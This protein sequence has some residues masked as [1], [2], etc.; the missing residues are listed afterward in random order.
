MAEAA[1]TA[2]AAS[3]DSGHAAVCHANGPG[4][5]VRGR[6]SIPDP[7]SRTGQE[8]ASRGGPQLGSNQRHLLWKFVYLPRPTIDCRSV[9]TRPLPLTRSEMLL[10]SISFSRT[11]CP[12]PIKGVA[13][14]PAAGRPMETICPVAT[15]WTM[16]TLTF[17]IYFTPFANLSDM[18]LR[19]RPETRHSDS[20]IAI[21]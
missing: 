21:T 7:A 5:Y 11:A 6:R 20:T 15:S 9:S 3:P 19:I 12:S 17:A 10:S 13:L 8:A 4:R 16:K 1:A 14:T 2:G 18:E